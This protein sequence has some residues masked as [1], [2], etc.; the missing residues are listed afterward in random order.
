MKMKNDFAKSILDIPYNRVES[1]RKIELSDILDKYR[2]QRQNSQLSN[3][4]AYAE[5]IDAT[6]E[7]LLAYQNW[8]NDGK[9]TGIESDGQYYELQ[10]QAYGEV[11]IDLSWLI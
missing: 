9:P 10:K 1:G 3:L 4:D 6:R 11:I 2:Y 5:D 7:E 8:I